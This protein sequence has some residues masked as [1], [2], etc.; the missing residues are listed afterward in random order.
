M[1]MVAEEMAQAI[2]DNVRGCNEPMDTNNK[3]YRAICDYIESHAQVIY[4]WAGTLDGV[5]DPIIIVNATIKTF[6]SL[7]PTGATTPESAMAAW[8]TM[9]NANAATWMVVWPPDFVLTPAFIIPTINFTLS[10]AT[11][12]FPAITHVCREIINGIKMATPVATGSHIVYT[13]VA[14]FTEIL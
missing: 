14:S 2:I 6:G 5:P 7:T 4:A 9:W 1:A 13:G 11:E 8:S 3:L 10:G 12:Q